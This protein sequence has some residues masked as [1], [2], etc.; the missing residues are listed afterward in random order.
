MAYPVNPGITRNLLL[1]TD[2]HTD[3]PIDRNGLPTR[4]GE[5]AFQNA[6]SVTAQGACVA[7]VPLSMTTIHAMSATNPFL[8]IVTSNETTSPSRTLRSVARPCTTSSLTLM[9]VAYGES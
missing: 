7:V 1:R 4:I 5:A 6:F 8:R 9:S 2:R 3:R